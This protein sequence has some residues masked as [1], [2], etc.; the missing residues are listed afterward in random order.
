MCGNRVHRIISHVA[1]AAFCRQM[2]LDSSALCGVAPIVLSTMSLAGLQLSIED[3][4]C[5][6]FPTPAS[7]LILALAMIILAA[8]IVPG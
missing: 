3:V 2:R 1:V 5:R 7:K 8:C 4:L 6:W